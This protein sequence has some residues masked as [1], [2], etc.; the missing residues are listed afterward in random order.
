MTTRVKFHHSQIFQHE[1]T[2]KNGCHPFSHLAMSPTKKTTKKKQLLLLPQH[3]ASKCVFGVVEG[4]T[5]FFQQKTTQKTT[6]GQKVSTKKHPQVLEV[7]ILGDF[8]FP[9]SGDTVKLSCLNTVRNVGKVKR[10][11]N[12]PSNDRFWD[13]CNALMPIDTLIYCNW[14]V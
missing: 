4:Q 12:I 10:N 14:V 13:Y 8:F 5:C 2:S 7:D 6:P 11:P 9:A 1:S 3:H